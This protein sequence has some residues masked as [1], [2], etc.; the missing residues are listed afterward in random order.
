MNVSVTGHR[1][2]FKPNCLHGHIITK[3]SITT[4]PRKLAFYHFRLVGS[5]S[6][7]SLVLKQHQVRFVAFQN[8]RVEQQLAYLSLPCLSTL[9]AMASI[10]WQ[11]PLSTTFGLLSASVVYLVTAL[12]WSATWVVLNVVA[13]A[14]RYVVRAA[15]VIATPL[16]YP[17]YYLWRAVAFLLSPIWALGRMIAGTGSLIIAL[18]VKFKVCPDTH[19]QSFVRASCEL[20]YRQYLYI[21]VGGRPCKLAIVKLDLRRKY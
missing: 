21:F 5:P 11:T 16:T 1:A 17:L 8:A 3:F 12:Y 13:S 15:S 14:P 6:L 19:T 7:A 2:R 18:I 9:V 20:T 10:D 4:T